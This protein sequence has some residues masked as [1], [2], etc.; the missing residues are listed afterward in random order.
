MIEQILKQLE[1]QYGMP[2]GT[3]ERLLSVYE[4]ASSVPESEEMRYASAW[5]AYNEALD[6]DDDMATLARIY[7]EHCQLPLFERINAQGTFVF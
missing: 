1:D 2:V 4:T 5:D 7:A 3:A 6:A